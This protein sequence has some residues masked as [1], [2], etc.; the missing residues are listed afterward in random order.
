MLSPHG[1]G[2]D[3][4]VAVNNVSDA[5]AVGRP[6]TI[7]SALIIVGLVVTL[8][9]PWVVFLTAGWEAQVAAWIVQGI[10]AVVMAIGALI[11]Q[12]VSLWRRIGGAVLILA[13]TVLDMLFWRDFADDTTLALPLALVLLSNGLLVAGALLALGVRRWRWLLLVA[14]V[15]S[16][17][18]SRSASGR[19]TGGSSTRPSTRSCRRSICSRWWSRSSSCAAP[20]PSPERTA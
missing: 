16:C 9:G 6:S 7:S 13:G 14:V 19:C 8:G 10:A 3:K 17:S 20:V 5:A 2:A 11:R 18:I 1:H 4:G 15:S 12:S